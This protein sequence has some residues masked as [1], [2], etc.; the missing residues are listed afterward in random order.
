MAQRESS[1]RYFCSYLG[2]VY[3][4]TPLYNSV[5]VHVE[6]GY[7]SPWDK[8]D[9]LRTYDPQFCHN[10]NK[11]M[12]QNQQNPEVIKII[13]DPSF[14]LAILAVSNVLK[15]NLTFWDMYKYYDNYVCMNY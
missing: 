4:K 6:K 11:W 10:Q 15:T 5:P 12:T 3:V 2:D 8:G 13:N 7:L 9:F 14:Q 1:G